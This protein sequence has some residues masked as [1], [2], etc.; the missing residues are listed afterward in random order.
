MLTGKMRSYIKVLPNRTAN[1]D[2]NQVDG[3]NQLRKEY[4]PTLPSLQFLTFVQAPTP[5][6]PS[7]EIRSVAARQHQT[8]NNFKLRTSNNPHSLPMKIL[9]LIAL[10][11]VVIIC[12]AQDR[13]LFDMNMNAAYE[14][15]AK[16]DYPRAVKFF[17]EA[18]GSPVLKLDNE[19]NLKMLVDELARLT[20]KRMELGTIQPVTR[21][22]AMVLWV[23][24]V[25]GDYTDPKK[26]KIHIDQTLSEEDKKWA[27]I[28]MNVLREIYEAMSSG[29]FT[30]DFEEVSVS[31]P[32]QS[33]KYMDDRPWPDWDYYDA[34]ADIIRENFDTHDTFIWCTTLI[35]GQAI[36][37]YSRFPLG[38]GRLTP[39][40]GFFETNPRFSP[41]MWIHEFFHVV[42]NMMDIKPSHGHHARNKPMFPEW[43]GKVNNELDYYSWQFS[44]TIPA[45]GWDKL[46]VKS[47]LADED[48]GDVLDNPETYDEVGTWTPKQVTADWSVQEWKVDS[49]KLSPGSVKVMMLYTSGWK[50]LDIEWV[51]IWQK[52]KQIAID[53]H[54]GFSGT[55]KRNIVYTFSIPQ[56]VKGSAFTIKAKVKGDNG[57]DSNGRV[58]M[59]AE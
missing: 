39:Q 30:V 49:Y 58:L 29:N 42:E 4:K 37:G 53:E 28:R 19:V 20:K 23:E 56:G 18:Q 40:K 8:S 54:F 11:L 14:A 10:N 21:H 35:T 16:S 59:K 32:L 33:I 3:C 5:I 2:K 26:G 25:N 48:P 12:P 31:E 44:T 41:N 6:T 38:G 1:N 51:S 9:I 34:A 17:S 7:G 15:L 50:A 13:A 52:D 24:K 22:K 57:T 55:K 36:G 46:K 47:K 45:K 43:K 27:R